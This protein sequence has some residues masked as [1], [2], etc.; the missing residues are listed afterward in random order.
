VLAEKAVDELKARTEETGWHYKNGG[1]DID[2]PDIYP[3]QHPYQPTVHCT[4]TIGRTFPLLLSSHLL[5]HSTFH[6]I[7]LALNIV[8]ELA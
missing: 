3:P 8:T 2:E 1:E 6:L 4:V 7:D 5:P